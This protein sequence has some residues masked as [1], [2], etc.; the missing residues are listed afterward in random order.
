MSKGTQRRYQPRL[1]IL[2][3]IALF[4]AIRSVKPPKPVLEGRA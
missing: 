4:H 1:N 3:C 2:A